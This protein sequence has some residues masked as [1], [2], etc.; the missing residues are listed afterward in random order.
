[1]LRSIIRKRSIHTVPK[2]PNVDVLAKKGIPPVLSNKG[3]NTVWT[4]YQTYLCDKLTMATAGTSLES[5]Y[6]F[7]IVLNTAKKSFQSHIFNLA[8]ATHN[9]HLFIENILPM[10]THTKTGGVIENKLSELFLDRIERSFGKKWEELKEDIINDVDNKLL[11][12]GWFCLV[13][14]AQKQLQILYLQNNGTPY[15]FPRNQ[16]FDM[17]SIINIDEFSYLKQIKELVNN[18]DEKIK[19]WTLPIIMVNLWDYAYLEDYGVAKR[20]EYMRNVL[21]NLN[22]NVINKRLYN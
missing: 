4:E 8:S 19:D 14:N 1:M 20:K 13:E 16:L 11:G 21:N 15:Y 5:Y 3:F 9:N 22:W 6:P 7:H 18:K 17:N 12:Q 10:E 2:L